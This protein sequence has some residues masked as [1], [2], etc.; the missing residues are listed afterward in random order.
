MSK[1][2]YQFATRVAALQVNPLREQAK[3]SQTVDHYI[4]LTY[5]YPSNEAFPVDK[6][7]KLSDKI[8]REHAFDFMQYGESEGIPKLRSQIKARLHK[9]QALNI[10]DNDLLITSGSTQG[11]DLV[12]KL[13][14]N[15]GDTVLTEEQTFVGAV[16]AIKSYG[17]YA[18]GL[19][20]DDAGC[21]D[22]EVLRATLAADTSHQIKLLYLIPTFQ[23]PMGTSMTLEKRQAVYD[24]CKQYQ[25]M[26]YEDDPYG[27]LLYTDKTAIPKI[28]SLDDVGIVIYAGSFSKILAPGSRLGYLL[29]PTAVF[30]QLILVKQVADSFSNLYWQY[31][32]SQ[33]F[34][35]YDFNKHIEHLRQ[36][37]RLKLETMIN[38]LRAKCQKNMSF[39]VPEGGYF[40]SIKLNDDIDGDAFYDEITQRQVG[41]IPGNIMSAAGKGYEKYFR[42]N[43]TLPTL[44]EI[45]NGIS[46]IGAAAEAAKK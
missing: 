6:L 17:G 22:T 32:A 4:K 38:A 37:Y 31:L 10:S 19:P 1:L 12:F 46:R 33:L 26:I 23:N 3:N 27:D 29:A 43:F 5:G 14:V 15:E 24:I 30:D 39:S 40:V 16:N 7:A 9:Y 42:L 44:V 28:K 45:E 11:M 36:L 8:Y 20:F 25:V 13:F 21:I 41:V 35:D 18:Q 34:E 2:S